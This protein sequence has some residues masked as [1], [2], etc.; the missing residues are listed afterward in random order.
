[1][2]QLAG[3]AFIHKR[4]K[5]ATLQIDGNFHNSSKED[6]NTIQH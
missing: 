4:I 3:M 2:G 6:G 1:M 5:L